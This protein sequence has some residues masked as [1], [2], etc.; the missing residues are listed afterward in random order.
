MHRLSTYRNGLL[1]LFIVSVLI[2]THTFSHIRNT[3]DSAVSG[4]S[5]RCSG[6]QITWM[7]LDFWT[8]SQTWMSWN[9]WVWEQEICLISPWRLWI[10]VLDKWPG[11]RNIWKFRV[12]KRPG[13][14]RN[15][16]GSHSRVLL[17][18]FCL[19]VGKRAWAFGYQWSQP[20]SKFRKDTDNKRMAQVWGS[21][22][23]AL[24]T[25]HLVK[26]L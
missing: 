20:K 3:L 23:L 17:A 24:Q 18:V 8:P 7:I 4:C 25:S 5:L 16:M 1:E 15:L 10:C 19:S 26:E 12:S 13:Q 14:E 22:Q 9:W 21:Y 2:D 11:V 6:V